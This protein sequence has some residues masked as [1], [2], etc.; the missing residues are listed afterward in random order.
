MEFC[1]RAIINLR[2][3]CLRKKIYRGGVHGVPPSWVEKEDISTCTGRGGVRSVSPSRDIIYY[4][5]G[6]YKASS[7]SVCIER[8]MRLIRLCHSFSF[9]FVF[10]SSCRNYFY[11]RGIFPFDAVLSCLCY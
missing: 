9:G 8:S 5:D 11:V 7:P 1:E 3:E 6:V 10:E 2:V 4:D